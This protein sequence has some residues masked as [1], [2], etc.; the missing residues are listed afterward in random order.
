[1]PSIHGLPYDHSILLENLMDPAHLT[2]SYLL[3]AASYACSVGKREDIVEEVDKDRR[4]IVEE[5]VDERRRK[6]SS[7]TG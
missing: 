2:R 7:K 4:G 3:G 5:V 6:D 1:M